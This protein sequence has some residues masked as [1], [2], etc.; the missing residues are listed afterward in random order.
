MAKW[1]TMGAAA[2]DTI[3][4]VPHLPK[5]DEIVYPDSIE[6]YPGGSTANIAVG[7]SRLGETVSF[8]GK[9][10]DDANGKVICDSFREDGVETTYLKIEVGNSSGGAFIAVDSDGERV[11]YSLGGN[12][13]YERWDE[14]DPASFEGVDGLYIGETFDEVGVE[15]AKLAHKHGATVFFG[16]GGIMCSYGLEYL[17]IVIENTDYLLVNLPEAKML[18]GCDTKEEAIEKLLDAGAKNLILTEGKNGAGCYNK[19]GCITV[20]AFSVKAVDTTGAG[21]TFTAGLL[22]ALSVGFSI[23]KALR[24]AAACAA[25]AVQSVGARSSM[26][27]AEQMEVVWTKL[28]RG[29]FADRVHAALCALAIGDSMGMPTEF[30]PPEE[31]AE[32]YGWVDK[33]LNPDPRHYHYADMV[34]AQYTDDTELSLEVLDA[35]MR[36]GGVTLEVAVD[37]LKTWA[38]KYDVF[39]KSYL[40]PTSKKALESIFAGADPVET[41]KEGTTNGAAMRVTPVGIVNAG[42]PDKAAEDAAAL[43]LPT[44]GSNRAMAG[45]GAV[46]AA[47]AEAL[48]AGSTVE[49]IMAAA[50]RGAVIAESKGFN[51]GESRLLVMLDEMLELSGRIDEDEQFI[52]EVFSRIEYSMDCEETAAVVLTYFSRCV[53]DPMHAARLGANMG[54]DT[55]TIGALAAALCG[56]YSGTAKLDM[57]MVSEIEKVNNVNFKEK[58]ASVLKFVSNTYNNIN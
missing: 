8:Y 26:P 45:A 15:A 39:N 11:I 1:I 16:P 35:I 37:A 52:R 32:F 58:A 34:R 53:G 43:C 36:G 24:F 46:A 30:Q 22:H 21:D 42:N 17:G 40:G 13:L 47:V 4:K 28:N 25:T 50:R 6:Q 3:V 27:T 33:L 20:P 56:A 12:T 9:A 55:D 23:E 2:V 57:D 10:G 48:S 18:S 31:I 19:A 49:S 54:G 14:I 5:A 44:H 41:G 7:L 29:D 38:E 51:K